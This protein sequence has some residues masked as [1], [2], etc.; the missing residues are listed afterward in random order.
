[1]ISPR[2]SREAGT[3][4]RESPAVAP[5]LDALADRIRRLRPSHRDPEH[6]HVEKDAIEKELR[7]LA[8][9]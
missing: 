1:M 6:F 3:P 8:R 5:A 2:R 7:R 9:Q 4:S